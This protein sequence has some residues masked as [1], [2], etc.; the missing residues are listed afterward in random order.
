MFLLTSGGGSEGSG[1]SGFSSTFIASSSECEWSAARGP[2]ARNPGAIR[3]P[4]SEGCWGSVGGRRKDGGGGG[5]GGG[6]RSGRGEEEEKEAA[7]C[8]LS[9]VAPVV[10]PGRI[11]ALRRC[12]CWWWRW[13]RPEEHR[14][15]GSP[16]H[17]GQTATICLRPHNSSTEREGARGHNETAAAPRLTRRR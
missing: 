14:K 12:C 2:P 7:P 1:P 17:S 5:R 9:N 16:T 10:A 11:V 15:R 8:L 6:R 13:W 4:A 3:G